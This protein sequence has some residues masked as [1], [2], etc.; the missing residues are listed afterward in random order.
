MVVRLDGSDFLRLLRAQG[1]SLEVLSGRA[2]VTEDG[3][4]GDAFLAPGRRY[5]VR[6]DGLVLVGA[7]GGA[8]ELALQP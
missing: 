5:R 2:W 8:V 1:T 6:G 7:E 4:G 3:R